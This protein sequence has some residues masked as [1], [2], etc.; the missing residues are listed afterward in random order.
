MTILHLAAILD[1]HDVISWLVD[2]FGETLAL[3]QNKHGQCALHFAA[4][5]GLSWKM[6]VF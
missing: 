6:S 3:I 2:A 4:A 5:K 1:N